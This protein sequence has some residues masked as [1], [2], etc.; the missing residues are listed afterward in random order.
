[1]GRSEPAKVRDT[2]HARQRPNSRARPQGTEMPVARDS[3]AVEV[4]RSYTA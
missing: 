1:V 2:D 3:V 4:L